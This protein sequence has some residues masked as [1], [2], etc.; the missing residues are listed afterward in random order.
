[1]LLLT[2]RPGESIRIGD[3]VEVHVLGIKGNQ[4]RYGVKAPSD[5]SVHRE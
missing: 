4:V 3:D 2:R 5:I 1:M